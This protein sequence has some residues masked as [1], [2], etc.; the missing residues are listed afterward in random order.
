MRVCA[1]I[2]SIVV[3]DVRVLRL[4]MC[5]CAQ[6]QKSESILELDGGKAL[7]IVNVLSVHVLNGR[8][9]V[10]AITMHSM[11]ALACH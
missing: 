5:L 1:A 11:D 2:A 8:G 7:R 10:Y 3:Q 6:V 9:Q 4:C